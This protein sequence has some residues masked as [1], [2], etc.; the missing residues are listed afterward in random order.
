ML[1][2]S[3]PGSAD[4]VKAFS[5]KGLSHKAYGWRGIKDKRFTYVIFNGYA[6]GE[7]QMEYLYDNIADPYQLHPEILEP[8][9]QRAEVLAYREALKNYLLQTEDPFLWNR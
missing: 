9:C 6:P 1:I 2:C 5:D 7:G 4:M 8:D 3:Y